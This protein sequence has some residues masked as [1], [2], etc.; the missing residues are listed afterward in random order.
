MLANI[1]SRQLKEIIFSGAFFAGALRVKRMWVC[2]LLIAGYH[3]KY[4]C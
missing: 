3:T 2:V 1:C 4:L